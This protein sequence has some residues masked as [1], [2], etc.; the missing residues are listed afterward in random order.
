[1]LARMVF[2]GRGK[3]MGTAERVEGG[4][5]KPPSLRRLGSRA[6]VGGHQAVA[7]QGRGRAPAFGMTESPGASSS[8]L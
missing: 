6:S 8:F 1:M 4:W 5:K 3:L 2:G 7:Y